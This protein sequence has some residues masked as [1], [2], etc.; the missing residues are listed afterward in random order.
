M[1]SKAKNHGYIIIANDNTP[2]AIRRSVMNDKNAEIG[3]VAD[4]GSAYLTDTIGPEVD[5]RNGQHN[6]CPDPGNKG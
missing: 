2:S 4:N 3:I 6:T 5:P 1:L